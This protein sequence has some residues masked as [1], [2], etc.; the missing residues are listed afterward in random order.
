MRC[1]V[2][3]DWEHGY[4]GRANKKSSGIRHKVDEPVLV[5][6][7]D[8]D[9]EED[10]EDTADD[11]TAAADAYNGREQCYTTLVISV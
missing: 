9:E 2:T 4:L 6:D 1:K 10:A 8:D 11:G 5:V 3:A 7:E